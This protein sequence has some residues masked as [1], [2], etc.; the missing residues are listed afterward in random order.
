MTT[1]MTDEME[2]PRAS[3]SP[4]SSILIVDDEATARDLCADVAR[5]AGLLVRTATTTEQALEILEQYP[6]DIVLT[7]LTLPDA[8]RG[9]SATGCSR[10]LGRSIDERGSVRLPLR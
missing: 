4:G 8:A 6:V 9:T 2:P 7:D 10:P 5:E 1:T 3:A